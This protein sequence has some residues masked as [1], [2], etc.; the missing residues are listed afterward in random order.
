ML[1]PVVF[2]DTVFI[3]GR[4][5]CY[6]TVLSWRITSC[7]HSAICDRSTCKL[8]CV[9]PFMLLQVPYNSVYYNYII[10]MQWLVGWFWGQGKK[11]VC[12]GKKVH[13]GP[14]LWGV[15]FCKTHTTVL[16][17]IWHFCSKNG[18]AIFTVMNIIWTHYS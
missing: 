9:P 5:N 8:F 10:I 18:Y 13:C 1:G 15:G 11:G 2:V 16:H 14:V 4:Q 17:S 6:T 12:V 3:Q 7:A